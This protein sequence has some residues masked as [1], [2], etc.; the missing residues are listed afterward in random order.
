MLNSLRTLTTCRGRLSHHYEGN[1]KLRQLM[2]RRLKN[3]TPKNFR[4]LSGTINSWYKLD[5]HSI[6]SKNTLYIKKMRF[7]SL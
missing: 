2:G 6:I 7:Y 3:Q 4:Y 1:R 5:M